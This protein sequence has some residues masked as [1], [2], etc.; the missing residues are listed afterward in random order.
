MNALIISG[1]GSL[2]AWGAGFSEFLI[3][4]KNRNYTVA[5]GTSTGALIAPVALTG[6]F[7]LLQSVYT[8]TKN[9]DIF[10]KNPFKENGKIKILNAVCRF[11]SGKKT[12][13]E[14]EGLLEMISK[15]FTKHHYEDIIRNN[16]RCFVTVFN[17]NKM[18]VE[19]KSIHHSSY[20]EFVKWMWISANVPIM[21]SL[22]E[23]K[24]QQYA[25]GGIGDHIPFY[26]MYKK[27]PKHFFDVIVHRTFKEN[28]LKPKIKTTGDYIMRVLDA[29]LAENSK[30]DIVTASEYKNVNVF[31]LPNEIAEDKTNSSL[32]FEP[33]KMKVW[34]ETGLNGIYSK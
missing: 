26:P 13:G 15:N 17:L 10:S 34:Y 1:G 25:D 9:K 18:Q 24:G 19:Y 21:M 6:D 20:E 7:E 22:A 4:T 5:C 12:L 32:K 8:N 33:E 31:Y 23:V 27:F 11:L 30:Q 2:G 16:K 3:N 14:S 28:E 29:V